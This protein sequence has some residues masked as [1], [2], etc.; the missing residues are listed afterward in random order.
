MTDMTI[1]PFGSTAISNSVA[2]E[3]LIGLKWIKVYT[4]T[5]FNLAVPTFSVWKVIPFREMGV[6][7]SVV[8]HVVHR[9]TYS[10]SLM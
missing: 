2:N 4:I 3:T 8:H 5:L 10:F 1:M 9:I 7:H 6:V